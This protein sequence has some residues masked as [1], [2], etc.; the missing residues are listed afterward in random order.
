[1]PFFQLAMVANITALTVPIYQVSALVYYIIHLIWSSP[2]YMGLC[3]FSPILTPCLMFYS[4]L[5]VL[6]LQFHRELMQSPGSSSLK[7][8]LLFPRC[9]SR[10]TF[11]CKGP[12]ASL[13][14]Q[15]SHAAQGILQ[16]T[17]KTR[18]FP[19]QTTQ[20]LQESWVNTSN[21]LSLLYLSSPRTWT[22]AFA[23]ALLLLQRGRKKKKN[24]S[25]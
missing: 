19:S 8:H 6:L 21:P 11:S 7:L 17:G 5:Q 16:R 9:V 14:C 20:Q 24:L 12:S 23:C 18:G 10:V 3:F 15:A 22:A 13:L 1:M 4:S 2:T 25:P